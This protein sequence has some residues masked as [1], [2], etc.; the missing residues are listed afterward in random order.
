MRSI[1][2]E[3]RSRKCEFEESGDQYSSGTPP[4]YHDNSTMKED[5]SPDFE[6]WCEACTEGHKMFQDRKLHTKTMRLKLDVI[7]R[8]GKRLAATEVT[9]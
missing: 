5:G 7:R 8:L 9:P 2:S 1:T 4:C 3:L 6:Q